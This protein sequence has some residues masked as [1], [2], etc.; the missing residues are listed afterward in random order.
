M[1]A[2]K[3]APPS[4]KS[5]HQ[6]WEEA[7]W[8]APPPWPAT[9]G[10]P[11]W[12]APPPSKHAPPFVGDAPHHGGPQQASTKRG[13]PPKGAP[14]K[15]ASHESGDLVPH[16]GHCVFRERSLQKILEGPRTFPAPSK[17]SGRVPKLFRLDGLLQNISG[18]SE[19]L[20]P[21]FSLRNIFGV[22]ETFPVTF[23]QT[24]CLV[25]SR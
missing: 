21:K 9:W 11:S 22:S 7:P 25:L 14:P 6:R 12:G 15:T 1:K 3:G 23:S 2:Q 13:S 10:L 17:N 5:T 18:Y 19:T 16:P 8:G 24:P 4:T 20:P